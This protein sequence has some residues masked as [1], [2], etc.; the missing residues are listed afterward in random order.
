MARLPDPLASSTLTMQ[1]GLGVALQGATNAGPVLGNELAAYGDSIL[2]IFQGQNIYEMFATPS[3]GQD[4]PGNSGTDTVTW[5][6]Y[7]EIG[8]APVL[9]EGNPGSPQKMGRERV[10]KQLEQRG[11]WMQSTDRLIARSIHNIPD[12]MFQ[13][14]GRSYVN[15]RNTQAQNAIYLTTAPSSGNFPTAAQ[16]GSVAGTSDVGNTLSNVVYG[17]GEDKY[18]DLNSDSDNLSLANIR[19]LVEA[20]ENNHTP[21]LLPR[22]TATPNVDTHP[23]DPAYIGTT[24][25]IGKRVIAQLTTGT[26]ADKEYIFEPAKNYAQPSSIMPNE[27]GRTGPVRWFYSSKAAWSGSGIAK[28][29]ARRVS[30]FGE[31]YFGVSEATAEMFRLYAK[32]IG[33]SDSTD[34]LGQVANIGY[35]YTSAFTLLNPL[36]GGA[37][38]YATAT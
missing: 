3:I 36:Y 18:T 9:V 19:T 34:V 8:E 17:G 10:Q 32:G 24:D 25:L 5:W 14:I 37:I 1:R 27:F 31:N 11:T 6:R 4:L 35:K 26:G 33:E 22:I 23:G 29:K 38:F 21:T 12:I 13:R 20:L 2:E 30:I 15:T 28:G 16:G 7:P